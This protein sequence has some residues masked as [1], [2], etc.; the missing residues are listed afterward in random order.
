MFQKV[1]YRKA[2]RPAAGAGGRRIIVPTWRAADDAPAGRGREADD[3]RRSS[4]AADGGAR[5]VLPAATRARAAHRSRAPGGAAEAPRATALGFRA[6]TGPRSWGPGGAAESDRRPGLPDRAPPRRRRGRA[7][8]PP[9][10]QQSARPAAAPDAA[11]L[12]TVRVAYGAGVGSMAPLWMAKAAGAFE[13]AA[14]CGSRWCPSSPAPGSPRWWPARSTWCRFRAGHDPRGGPGRG[15]GVHR[16]GAEQH[17][18]QR[19]RSPRDRGGG[20]PAREA[21]GQRRPGTPERLR[22]PGRAGASRAHRCR[23]A[24]AERRQLGPAHPGAPGRP[25]RVHGAGAAAE[26]RGRGRR[27][28]AAHRPVRRAVPDHRPRRH[29]RPAGAAGGAR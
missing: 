15:P 10:A 29:P 25:A 11:A 27:L 1:G 2:T 26:L 19:A 22:H 23:R 16:R 18:P 3:G 28:P 5:A 7:A 6:G 12:P 14:V 9:T 24:G 17:D 13:R 21:L 8:V 4:G 20:R